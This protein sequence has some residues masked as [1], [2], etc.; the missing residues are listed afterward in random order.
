[1][2]SVCVCVWWIYVKQDSAWEHGISSASIRG[3]PKFLTSSV[4]TKFRRT[5]LPGHRLRMVNI[6]CNTMLGSATCKLTGRCKNAQD[7]ALCKTRHSRGSEYPYLKMGAL[8]SSETSW[9]CTNH[10]TS[11]SITQQASECSVDSN[12]SEQKP[13]A[14][15]VEAVM[16][17]LVYTI[18]TV[19]TCWEL[20]R[21]SVHLVKSSY[22]LI[23]NGSGKKKW[24]CVAW[25]SQDVI[26]WHLSPSRAACAEKRLL[27]RSVEYGYNLV[28]WFR[29]LYLSCQ[30]KQ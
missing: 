15:F 4:S 27:M 16:N 9:P 24:T 25:Q 26:R 28:S 29:T 10:K 6:R 12:D 19:R 14:H 8:S 2:V 21:A 3:R 17:C 18:Q 23:R 13:K 22:R 1:M 7:S 11:Q 20:Q 30:L 5:W